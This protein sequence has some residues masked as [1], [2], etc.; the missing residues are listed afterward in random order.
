MGLW[1]LAV[2]FKSQDVAKKKVGE[3]SPPTSTS[4][5]VG[6]HATRLRT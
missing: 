2:T 4:P 3:S 1:Q 6:G 5:T